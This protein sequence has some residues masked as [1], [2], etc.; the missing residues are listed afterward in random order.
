M[1]TCKLKT[2]LFFDNVKKIFFFKKILVIT[3][4]PINYNKKDKIFQ[5]ELNSSDHS[6]TCNLINFQA[7]YIENKVFV[8]CY[9]SCTNLN[10]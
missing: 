7:I 2:K 9:C 8:N 1:F 6:V 3:I 4:I 10:P 5:K